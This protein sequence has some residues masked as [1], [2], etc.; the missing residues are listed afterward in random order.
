MKNNKEKKIL[1]CLV[2]YYIKTGLPIG[3]SN[4][5][6]MYDLKWG[7]STVRS[8]LYNLMEKGYLI[9]E[10]VS[11]GRVPNEKGIKAYIDML[12][13]RG[14][15]N[16]IDSNEDNDFIQ[17]MYFDF[18]GT[19]DQV[20]N[21]VSCHLSDITH[22]V[23]LATLPSKSNMKIQSF[24]I[25]ELREMEYLVFIVFKGGVTEKVY[26]KMDQEIPSNRLNQISEYLNKLTFGLTLNELK[27]KILSKVSIPFNEYSSFIETLIRLSMEILEKENDIDVMINGNVTH[28][29]HDNVDNLEISKNLLHI[30]EEKDHL[31][32]FM[33]KVF[34]D[35][36]TK[37][38]IGSYN[39]MPRG[40]SLIAAPYGKGN[41]QGSLGVFGPIRMNYSEIIPMV[42]YTADYLTT[43]I[44]GGQRH[45][46]W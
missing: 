15:E 10:H 9:Q 36:N 5:I 18:D 24:K 39:G 33:N 21:N 14:N 34:E 28:V 23:C 22:T 19:L 4:L 7:P 8:V 40:L 17:T 20:V 45:V 30:Y 38:F 37:V 31:I 46:S 35:N 25:V 41:N 43:L 29:E 27:S 11:S 44:E 26:I 3:S 32:E 2:D 16:S 12:F 42:N 6:K 1:S 13:P